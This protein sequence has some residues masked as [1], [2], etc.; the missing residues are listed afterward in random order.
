MTISA[1]L[2]G[3]W[4]LAQLGCA[5]APGPAAES[6]PALDRAAA[7]IT[8]AAIAAPGRFLSEDAL[9]GRGP[10]TRGEA[11]ASRFLISQ[12][13][14]LGLTPAGSNGGWEQVVDL[15]GVTTSR[16][17]PLTAR[18]KAGTPLALEPL[19]DFV[20]T[21]T[22]LAKSQHAWRD[23]EVVFVGYGIQEPKL[24]WDDYA[25]ADVRGKVVLA[26]MNDPDWDPALFAGKRR[27]YYGTTRYKRELAASLGAVGFIGI[28][29]RESMGWPW[30]VAQS[31]FG[32]ENSQL[33]EPTGPELDL[34]LLVTSEAADRI[35][36]G[37]GRTLASLSAAARTKGFRAMPLG[38]TLALDVD[39]V[40]RPY[41]GVNV[42]G[43]LRGSDLVLRDEYVVYSAHHDHLGTKLVDGKP[44][45]YNGAVD[46]AM[47][48]AGVLA[49]ANAFSALPEP[50]GRSI[51][52]LLVTAEE[53]GLLGSEHFSVHPTVPARSLVADIN[54]DSGNALGRSPTLYFMGG[55]KSSLHELATRVAAQ[56][57]RT[58]VE[59]PLPEDGYF[60]RSDQFSFAR[61]GVPSLYF[62]SGP[63]IR[64]R[65]AGWGIEQQK[66]YLAERY[67]QPSDDWE[68]GWDL[69]GFVEDRP[70]RLPGRFR[71]REPARARLV[72][73]GRRVRAG[74]SDA[75]RRVVAVAERSLLDR[76]IQRGRP[77]TV[78]GFAPP[79]VEIAQGL[80]SLERRLRMPGG[81]S[82][83]ARTTLVRL[84][85]GGL[86]V[87]SPPAVEAGG[88]AALD[89]LGRV[90]EVLLPNSFHY[91][92]A[93]P[94][95]G[96]YPHAVLRLAPSLAARVPDLPR[97]EEL[98]DRTPA[99]WLPT[100]EHTA[101]GPARGVSEVALFHPA[102]AT[103]IL[104]DVAFPR[105]RVRERA[106]ARVLEAR[107]HPDRVWAEP[108]RSTPASVGSR[109]GV[110]LSRARAALAL[111]SGPGGSRRSARGGCGRGVPARVRGLSR[112][113]SVLRFELS[114]RA[115]HAIRDHP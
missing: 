113:L 72:A 100:L 73:P 17:T 52:F 46:N 23:V 11:L 105:A 43:E 82:L 30:Q 111:P 3:G 90:E 87:V 45:I 55:D 49:I 8:Q 12:L 42:V 84:A 78:R 68:S 62:R 108:Q 96:R 114:N 1:A 60:Y 112:T 6:R 28:H 47:G 25:G 41:Q 50:P 85:S 93:R 81:P 35:A 19:R 39:T 2:L 54:F 109:R 63:E 89:A 24:G 15:V 110:G 71:G 75:P 107:G 14:A 22:S 58:I 106:R 95:L 104:T 20:V 56:Q 91:L 37:A 99:S 86:L 64:G 13:E 40:L 26:L 5:A 34:A 48:V 61:I 21:R 59:E 18:G 98:T 101:L 97:G 102:S 80:W 115:L 51:L 10:G 44:V 38:E 70:A 53:Q 33:A 94:F 7:T 27:L 83:P 92:N 65:P 77:K 16:V 76:L 36:A 9:E 67:H 4:I 32:A 31:S 66:R 74:G 69:S 29:T 88:L 103:L 79:P 57:G